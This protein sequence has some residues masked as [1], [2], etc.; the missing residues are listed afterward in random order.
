MSRQRD[1]SQPIN[2]DFQ[3]SRNEDKNRSNLNNIIDSINLNSLATYYPKDESLF[4]KRIDKLN[5]KF[6]LETE[7]Y[8][9]NTN[10]G[11]SLRCQD[12]LFMILF[13]QISL[14]I[15]EIERLNYV[16]R[17]RT[18]T[19][20][21]AKEKL[22]EMNK[23]DKESQ[24]NNLVISNLKNTIKMLE[25]KLNERA[26]NEE[27]LRQENDSYKRQIKFY[28]EKLQIEITAKKNLEIN[29]NRVNNINRLRQNEKNDENVN[30]FN[31]TG[32]ISSKERDARSGSKES[33]KNKF[34]AKSNFQT[35]N[36]ET[37]QQSSPKNND[38]GSNISPNV[39][40]NKKL[41][42]LNQ[43]IHHPE[44]SNA[45]TIINN[46]LKILNKKRNYSDNNPSQNN[47]IKKNLFTNIRYTNDT[48][49][50]NTIATSKESKSNNNNSII[51]GSESKNT[52]H[53]NSNN[54]NS[55]KNG[56]T[57]MKKQ[58]KSPERKDQNNAKSN[59][60]NTIVKNNK[61]D[62]GIIK[63]IKQQNIKLGKIKIFN[64]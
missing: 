60:N 17:E 2:Q 59:F 26:L 50:N 53:S 6:Y 45:N 54:Y 40:V 52:L 48:N 44:T 11:D 63:S 5:L 9:G 49:Q 14:Y 51:S 8:L 10:K 15:E 7:K 3:I 36:T 4:K 38:N 30:N 58:L 34:L 19:D 47:Q 18:D 31:M 12:T 23:K 29:Q 21:S 20:K 16:A 33:N 55:K 1:R 41:M 37:T 42:N 39:N 64:F 43:P 46:N 13:K 35:N 56:V 24:A 28:K 62:L 22:E 27:K 61:K 32:K 57:D 25:K